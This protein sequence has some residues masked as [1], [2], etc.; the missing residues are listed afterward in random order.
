MEYLKSK[1]PGSKLMIKVVKP[2]GRIKT[3]PVI[4]QKNDTA[5]VGNWGMLV[6][7]MT[8]KELR[9]RGLEN[10]VMISQINN[11]ELLSNG[12]APG[13]VIIKINNMPVYSA[14][15]V[16]R[17]L[18]DTGGRTVVEM[19]DNQGERVRYIFR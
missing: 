1:E 17:L 7:N 9:K 14:D 10:G 13:F 11:R 19:Q 3:L 12:I 8:R 16:S 2:D 5:Y 4:L 6:K 18:G 15:D